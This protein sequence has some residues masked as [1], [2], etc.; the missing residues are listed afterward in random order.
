VTKHL[1]RI[2]PWWLRCPLL[3]LWFPLTY[4]HYVLHAALPRRWGGHPDKGRLLCAG[5][6]LMPVALFVAAMGGRFVP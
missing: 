6:W 5:F 1:I 4:L 3:A 2:G